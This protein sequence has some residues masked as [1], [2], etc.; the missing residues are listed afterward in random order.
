M[1]QTCHISVSEILNV[2]KS[3]PLSDSVRIMKL[4]KFIIFEFTIIFILKGKL[5]NYY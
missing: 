4:S 2:T 5:N 1:C 3:A